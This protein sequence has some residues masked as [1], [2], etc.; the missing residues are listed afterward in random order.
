MTPDFD[1]IDKD[2]EGFYLFSS[3]APDEKFRVTNLMGR[4]GDDTEDLED[5]YGGV[6]KIREDCYMVFTFPTVQ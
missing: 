4:N 5:A 6:V 2:A 3:A 1:S